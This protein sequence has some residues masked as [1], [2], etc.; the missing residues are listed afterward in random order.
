MKTILANRTRIFLLLLAA[1]SWPSRGVC[2]EG[3]KIYYIRHAEGGHNVKRDW[4]DVPKD[5]WPDYVGDPNQFTPLGKKQLA[6]VSKTLQSLED[7]FDYI[8]SSPLWRSR[9]TILP[10]MKET[11]A[12]AEVWAELKELSASSKYLFDPDL[13]KVTEPILGQG[14]EL[15][16]PAD[17]AKWFS[18]RKDGLRGF[19]IPDYQN[20]EKK[21]AAAK[22]VYQAAIDRIIAEFGG[23]DKTILLAGHGASGKGLIRLLTNELDYDSIENTGIWMVEQQANGKFKV[24]MYN[25]VAIDDATIRFEDLRANLSDAKIN[26]QSSDHSNVKVT[27]AADGLDIVYSFLYQ[28]QD[29]DGIGDANDSLSWDI[30]FQGYLGGKITHDKNNSSVRLG[31]NAQ[32]YSGGKYFGVSDSRYVDKND[33]IQFSVENVVLKSDA[34]AKAKF[35]GFDRLFGTDDTYVFGVGDKS[36]KSQVTKDDGDITFPPAKVLTLS[37]PKGKFRVRDLAG[38]FTIYEKE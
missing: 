25:S 12:K 23:T 7:R 29:F 6:A 20:E 11:G 33:T 27:Q 36:L 13:P 18:I 21:T 28:N 31:K 4:E 34:G 1:F 24:K 35:N 15:A 30:R 26:R 9:N 22:V 14:S 5:K 3:L 17:E 37:C 32:V 8:A 10:Y 16:L 38:S 19:K 2:E